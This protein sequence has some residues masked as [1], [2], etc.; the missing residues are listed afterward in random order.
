ML[1]IQIFYSVS[2]FIYI[3]HFS[4]IEHSHVNTNLV[5]QQ[6]RMQNIGSLPIESLKNFLTRDQYEKC[7]TKTNVT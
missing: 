1:Y 6:Y 7:V 4:F 2:Y 5:Y 3:G